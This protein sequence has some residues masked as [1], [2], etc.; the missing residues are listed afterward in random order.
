[1]QRAP[2]LVRGIVIVR[3]S[4]LIEGASDI[5]ELVFDA[6]VTSIINGQ[7]GPYRLSRGMRRVDSTDVGGEL[8]GGTQ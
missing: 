7:I 4:A 6:D 8:T 3:G 5:A 2:S 1:M